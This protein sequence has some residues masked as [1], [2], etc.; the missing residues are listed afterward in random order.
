MLHRVVWLDCV[1][2]VAA[3]A[4]WHC[5][6]A[7]WDPA[8]VVSSVGSFLR[9][10]HRCWWQPSSLFKAQLCISTAAAEQQ[11]RNVSCSCMVQGSGARRS[12]EPQWIA[13]S[14]CTVASVSEKVYKN[15]C[16][17]SYYDMF[18]YMQR[19]CASPLQQFDSMLVCLLRWIHHSLAMSNDKYRASMCV[20]LSDVSCICWVAGCE[21]PQK[22][23]VGASGFLDTWPQS[24]A[25]CSLQT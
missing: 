9:V 25:K 11:P 16:V 22:V 13:A 2:D 5:S 1:S 20:Q 24:H 6:G 17:C 8:G 3:C 12:Q 23:E 4:G 19:A 10:Q 15:G 7:F 18:V 21:L 14:C